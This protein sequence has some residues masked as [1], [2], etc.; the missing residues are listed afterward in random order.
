MRWN[1]SDCRLT[2]PNESFTP[3]VMD[4]LAAEEVGKEKEKKYH[5]FLPKNAHVFAQIW[6]Q[7]APH[8]H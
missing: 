6:A 4:Y 1:M 7:P 2:K 8:N 5:C 3:A